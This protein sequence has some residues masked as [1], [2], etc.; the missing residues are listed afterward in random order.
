[1][2]YRPWGSV[3][4]VLSLS[5]PKQWRYVGAIATEERSLCAWMELRK[6]GAV[7]S[8]LFAE[9]HDVESEKYGDR[10]RA[11]LQERRAIFDKHGGDKAATR[12][13]HLLS[14]LF[15]IRDFANKAAADQSS[16]ILDITSFPKRFYFPILKSL[17]NSENVKNLLLTYTQAGR[18]VEDAPLYE[19]IEHWKTLPG[20]GGKDDKPSLW[21]VSVGFLVES[22]NQ[23]ARDNPSDRMKVLVPFPAPLAALHRTWKSIAELERGKDGN[24]FDK[25]RV[26]PFDI[27]SAFDRI[28]SL[29]A[30]TQHL[31]FA[32]FGPKPI[33]AAMCLYAMQK[34]SSVHYPQPT[35]YHPDYSLGILNGSPNSAIRAYWI[36]HD[37]D[38]LYQI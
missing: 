4:W 9:I 30:S 23:Y 8:E 13:F 25:Y 3:D 12:S 14:E 1:M 24:R 20:F 5:T 26:D 2:T 15:N 29:A 21:I 19:D 7:N 38:F 18:Y 31:A 17:I 35:V 33:S 27:S 28:V 6:N 10:N 32:P 37:G 36:K 11:A 34:E 22:L 16:L